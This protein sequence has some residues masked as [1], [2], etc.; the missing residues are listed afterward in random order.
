MRPQTRQSND[1]TRADP[2]RDRL[3]RS[4]NPRPAEPPPPV[5]YA[6]HPAL[7]PARADDAVRTR[8]YHLWEAAGRPEGDGVPFWVQAERE[9]GK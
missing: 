6:P 1:F 4:T 9:L 3:A 2:D 7:D 5:V 8:A